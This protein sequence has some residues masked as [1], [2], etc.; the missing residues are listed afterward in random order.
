MLDWWLGLTGSALIAGLAY[1]RQ[2]LSVSGALAAIAVGTP[3][4]ALGS[5]QW[6]LP[7]IAFF[8]S[9][10]LLSKWKRNYKQEAETAYEKGGRRDAG[11]VLA[12]GGLGTVLCIAHAFYP[13]PLWLAAYIGVT[14]TVTADTWATEIGGLSR[15]QP[16]S[17]LTGR[18]V[19]PGTSG[20]VTGLGLLAAACGGLFIGIVA[21]LVEPSAILLLPVA[22]ISGFIGAL[23]DSFL[24]A[25][26]Q[27]MNRCLV[28]GRE[29]EAALH[30]GKP[31]AFYKGIRLLNNDAVNMISSA[32]GGLISTGLVMAYM[33]V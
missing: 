32:A 16:R 11:Q 19:L 26:V 14:A 2:S 22:L 29:V 24:G 33:M 17:L 31:T 7:L 15:N 12:N 27:R 28:C 21:T 13:T 23:A 30:C 5:A 18:T 9:S 20:G 3:L 25:A 4:Y 6:F 8:L 1:M 10:T